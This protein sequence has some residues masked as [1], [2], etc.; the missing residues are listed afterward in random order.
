MTVHRILRMALLSLIFVVAATGTIIAQESTEGADQEQ[1]VVAAPATEFEGT[2]MLGLGKYFYLPAAKGYDIYVQGM[3]Q[4]QDAT[5]L[6]NKEVRVKGS[7]FKEEP[8]VFIA[9]SIE[10]KDAAG[11][12]Q[13][14]FTRT[15]EPKLENHLHTQERG[16]YV[17]L[18][19]TKTDKSEDWEGK[20]KA[21]VHGKL[22]D[23]TIVLADDKGKEIGKILVDSTT[24]FASYYI[25]KLNLFS[26]FWFYLNVKETVD[27]KVRRKTRELFHADLIFAGLY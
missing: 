24:E 21:K 6:N 19:I 25:Q 16:G 4:G 1:A 3:I 26:K 17:A 14:V 15:E 20:G 5:F 9:D 8:S 2:A 23:N 27:A 7:M 10:V 18:A 11:Q 12:Y 13:T 22:V